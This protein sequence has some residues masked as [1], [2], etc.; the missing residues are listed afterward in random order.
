MKGKRIILLAVA[1]LIAGS[2]S[3][4]AYYY[5]S[6][7]YRA[8][9]SPYAGGLV[10]CWVRYCPYAFSDKHPSGLVDSYS[11]QPYC[12]GSVR[13]SFGQPTQPTQSFGEARKEYEE[14]LQLRQA[15]IEK[16]RQDS[17]AGESGKDIIC[18]YL[19]AK[20]IE[21]W[22][23]NGLCIQNKTISCEFLLKGGSL[24]KYWDM[25]AAVE[26]VGKKPE[27]GRIYKQY[28]DKW[29]AFLAEYQGQVW[30]IGR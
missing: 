14:W 11:G 13:G 7:H 17:L 3:A 20:G 22:I 16:L 5:S 4:Q 19:E 12:L 23:R 10:P 15:R 1:M 2:S 21:F 18:R 29:I 25:A 28:V 9:Y 8:R 30:E 24:I 27:Y 6:L 26:V